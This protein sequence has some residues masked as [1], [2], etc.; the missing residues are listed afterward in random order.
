MVISEVGVTLSRH[1]RCK[2][3]GKM[4]GALLITCVILSAIYT[5]LT[6]QVCFLPCPFPPPAPTTMMTHFSVSQHTEAPRSAF[7]LN[8]S[9]NSI[10]HCSLLC[11]HRQGNNQWSYAGLSFLNGNPDVLVDLVLFLLTTW[12]I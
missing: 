12:K 6:S 9:T 7:D 3:Q 4:V 1:W 5:F 11:R 8:T 2:P 10:R